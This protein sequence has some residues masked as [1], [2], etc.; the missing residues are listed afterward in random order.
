MDKNIRGLEGEVSAFKRRR[1]RRYMISELSQY[2]HSKPAHQKPHN[3]HEHH[4][5][6]QHAPKYNQS[7]QLLS[8]LIPTMVASVGLVANKIGQEIEGGHNGG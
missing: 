8:L 2:F 6:E 1:I 5:G 3:K 4:T 7:L